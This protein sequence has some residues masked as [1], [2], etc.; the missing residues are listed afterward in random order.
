MNA[1]PK[2]PG[3]RTVRPGQS[4]GADQVEVRLTV[5][6]PA[7]QEEQ[8]DAALSREVKQLA[9]TLGERVALTPVQQRKPHRVSHEAHQ[10]AGGGGDGARGADGDMTGGRRRGIE[11]EGSDGGG[12]TL[13]GR[14]HGPGWLISRLAHST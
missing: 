7:T 3:K 5:D 2:L 1:E 8:V 6:L 14:D 9:R 12:Q 10:P 11:D 13:F 4:P